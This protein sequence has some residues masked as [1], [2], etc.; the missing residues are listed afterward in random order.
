MSTQT[1]IRTAGSTSQ[2]IDLSLV[3]NAASTAAGDPVLG[4]AYNTTNLV[5]YYQVNG[6]GTLT[7]LSLVT[8]TPTGAYSSGGFIQRSATN[9]PGQYRF[10][11]PNTVVAT[12]G[13]ATVT[14]SGFPAG[15]AGNMET[16]TLHIMVTA[17]DLYTAGG[18]ILSTQLA[19]AVNANGT[20]PTLQ[21]AMYLALQILESLAISGTS[22]A[23][24]GIDGVTQIATLT[25]NAATGAT[26]VNRTA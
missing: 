16:H 18:G 26:S 4:V 2:S 6:T 8:Q 24:K 15:T 7:S 14:F 23:V 25:Y 20:M 10:D 13:Y 11:I 22:G 21:Q 9:A 12:G 19:N 17:V 5:A 3:Q 1:I